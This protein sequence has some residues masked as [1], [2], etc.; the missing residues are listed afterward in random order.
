VVAR[1]GEIGIIHKILT[2]TEQA[3]ETEKVKRNNQ[4]LLKIQLY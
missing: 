3:N 4:A 1:E 2:I